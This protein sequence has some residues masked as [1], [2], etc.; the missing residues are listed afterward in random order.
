MLRLISD[1]L[2]DKIEDADFFTSQHVAAHFVIHDDPLCM[3]AYS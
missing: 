2:P 3:H 1:D